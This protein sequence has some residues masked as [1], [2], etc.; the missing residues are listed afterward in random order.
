MPEENTRSEN[1]LGGYDYT[2]FGA[3]GTE[4]RKLMSNPEAVH[5]LLVKKRRANEEAKG[6]RIQLEAVAK[7]SDQTV[8]EMLS[9]IDLVNKLE[10]GHLKYSQLDTDEQ[11]VAMFMALDEVLD[12]KAIGIPETEWNAAIDALEAEKG[13]PE[14]EEEPEPANNKELE[15]LKANYEREAL[16]NRL[17]RDGAD[18]K[19]AEKLARLYEDP[20]YPEE[21]TDKKTGKPLDESAIEKE[22]QRINEEHFKTFR[23]DNPWGFGGNTQPVPGTHSAPYVPAAN[24]AD[25]QGAVQRGDARTLIQAAVNETFNGGEN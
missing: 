12:P 3:D 15:E 23:A 13:I 20:E 10:S 2:V 11:E 25:T 14:K 4:V 7:S 24:G 18:P 16:V 5:G 9:T 6:Y 1:K 22:K 21:Y 8:D 19:Q 17:M